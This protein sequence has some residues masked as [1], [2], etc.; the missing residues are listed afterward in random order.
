MAVEARKMES[1][2][3]LQNSHVGLM[4]FVPCGFCAEACSLHS[5]LLAAAEVGGA[6]DHVASMCLRCV[7]TTA[8]RGP[9]AWLGKRRTCR[10]RQSGVRNIFCPPDILLPNPTVRR[11]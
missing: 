9:A 3:R 5:L 6:F 7:A 11:A 10:S 4:R 8:R 1:N 2:Q